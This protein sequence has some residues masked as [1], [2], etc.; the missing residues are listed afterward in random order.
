MRR[1]TNVRVKLV[2]AL[3]GVLVLA[4]LLAA[5]A[6][7]AATTVKFSYWGSPEYNQAMQSLI[8]TFEAQNPDIKVETIHIPSKYYDKL[9]TMIAGG[10]APDVSML[11]FDRIPQFVEAGALQPIDSYVAKFRYPVNDLFPAVVN[12]FT[13]EGK[14]YGLPRSFSP[15]VLFYNEDMFKQAGLARSDDWKWAD[16]RAAAL[17]LTPYPGRPTFGF[18]S[19]YETDGRLF[20]EWLFPFIWQNGGEVVDPKTLRSRVL[21]DAT[22]DAIAFYVDLIQKDKVA[23]TSV[24]GQTYGGSPAM[25]LNRRAA[26]I[27]DAYNMTLSARTQ[28]GLNF[29]VMRLPYQKERATVVFPIGYVVP[30]A[31]KNA[32]AGFRLLAFLGGPEGQKI[33]PQLGL[34]MPGLRSIAESDLFLQ[35][36]Q[37]P[38]HSRVFLLETE[39][40]RPLPAHT[41][42]FQEWY[43]AWRQ[44]MEPV[45]A[46][47]EALDT[48]L[49]RVDREIN[50]ILSNK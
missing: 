12:G 4:M 27:I 16:F 7:E 50:R 37:Q 44:Q 18:A 33:V 28:Q 38:E 25:F 35:P 46:G 14:L 42:K 6:T 20:P 40:A 2:G 30:K 34:G 24:Q 47:T 49:V 41:P 8:K 39:I 19:H 36:G 3:A 29:D 9:L 15:F 17:K 23:P 5:T 31:A 43:E 11:A 10:D 1:F 48:A 26:M 13:F 22:R 45:M 21:E 32:D